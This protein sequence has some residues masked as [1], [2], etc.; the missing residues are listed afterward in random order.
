MV[1]LNS[2]EKKKVYAS[3]TLN[4]AI[5]KSN[6]RKNN[7]N[8]KLNEKKKKK[9]LKPKMY[10][11]WTERKTVFYCSSKI[12]SSTIGESVYTQQIST[13]DRKSLTNNKQVGLF[14]E[15]FK[16]MNKET[17][18]YNSEPVLILFIMK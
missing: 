10:W 3:Y 16:A 12:S 5:R 6:E 7:I 15:L 14:H 13:P 11:P 1:E 17:H 2:G 4:V 18:K 9:R 8:M